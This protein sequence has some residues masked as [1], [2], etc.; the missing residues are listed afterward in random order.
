MSALYALR[1]VGQ[2]G[3]GAGC[4]YFGRGRVLGIDVRGVKFDGTYIEQDNR[5]KASISMHVPAGSTLVIGLRVNQDTTIALTADWPADFADGKPQQMIFQG[6]PVA[7]TLTKL[8]D[9][10]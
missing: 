2:T 5:L 10:P 1:Y 6:R 7:V 9:I 8:G 3:I 4:I